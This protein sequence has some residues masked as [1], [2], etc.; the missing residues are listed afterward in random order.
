MNGGAIS[1][2]SVEVLVP[3]KMSA[4]TFLSFLEGFNGVTTVTFTPSHQP[5]HQIFPL[6]ANKVPPKP[7]KMVTIEAI[8]V[9]PGWNLSEFMSKLP[10]AGINLRRYGQGVIFDVPEEHQ[11]DVAALVSARQLVHPHA[12]HFR[13]K[14]W[15][16]KVGCHCGSLKH[17]TCKKPRSS[18]KPCVNCGGNYVSVDKK[19][20]TFRKE[21][22]SASVTSR[23]QLSGTQVVMDTPGLAQLPT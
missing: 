16:P 23:M 3:I 19:C 17:K 9:A 15:R 22:E 21:R 20:T 12:V 7:M 8:Y 1:S 10:I 11:K 6:V 5:P 4:K 14:I 2:L 18:S 13:P